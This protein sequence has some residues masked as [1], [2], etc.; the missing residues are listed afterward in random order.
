MRGVDGVRGGWVA[1]ATDGDDVV[2]WTVSASFLPL[3]D[4]ADAVVAVDIP[5]GLTTGDRRTCDRQ[6]RRLLPGRA[7]SVFPAPTLATA[8]DRREG[9]DHAEAV[10]RARD[11]GHPAPSIEAW[12]ITD[13]ITDV[14][15]AL[16][17]AAATTVVECHPEVTFARIAGRV[18]DRKK[19]AAGVGQRIA[20]LAG[21]L[22]AVSALAT[23]PAGVPVDD[24]LDA[25]A[26]LVTARRVRDG[27]AEPLGDPDQRDPSGRPL[28]IWV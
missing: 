21:H 10:R 1:A 26:C 6:A 25:L 4:S 9:V 7:S 22:D 16:A 12:N 20:A 3:L 11:R 13:K 24:A 27:T 15:D 23:V 19:T 2:T 14:A 17:A 8:A 5:I 28:L 18:L